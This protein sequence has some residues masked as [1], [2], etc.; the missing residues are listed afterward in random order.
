MTIQHIENHPMSQ[1]EMKMLFT[2]IDH[3]V[4]DNKEISNAFETKKFL[5]KC[6]LGKVPMPEIIVFDMTFDSGTILD[7]EWKKEYN[8]G[9]KSHFSVYVY[10][11]D[12]SID[13]DDPELN[14]LTMNVSASKNQDP[15]VGCLTNV[16]NSNQLSEIWHKFHKQLENNFS[17]DFFQLF[18]IA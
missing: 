4:F 6:I 3:F 5:D 7:L 17:D 18:K 14:R 12:V 10:K 2:Q 9:N 13:G 8:N 11:S 16:S 15:F 1:D